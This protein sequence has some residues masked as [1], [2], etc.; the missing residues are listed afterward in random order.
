MFTVFK[1][2]SLPLHQY[3]PLHFAADEGQVDTVRCLVDK[4]ADNY[5]RDRYHD[6]SE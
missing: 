1:S 5:F 6:V 2:V 4:G 3:T